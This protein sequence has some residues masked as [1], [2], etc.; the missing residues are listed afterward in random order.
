M[1]R[2]GINYYGSAF[3]GQPALVDYIVTDFT[4][5]PYGH[6]QIKLNWT[7]P[8]GSWNR[9]RLVRGTYGFPTSAFEGKELLDRYYGFDPA[10][11]L[12]NNDIIT[13]QTKKIIFATTL[14]PNEVKALVELLASAGKL[15]PKLNPIKPQLLS[16]NLVNNPVPELILP[17]FTKLSGLF[18]IKDKRVMSV[19]L[20]SLLRGVPTVSNL[21]LTQSTN[22]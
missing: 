17:I 6:G 22:A 18:S 14:K 10:A 15:A 13:Y 20:Q 1:S 3:Y 9:I 7:S 16:D 19:W 4:A 2:Y 12:D 8:S 5:V 21:E 11:L